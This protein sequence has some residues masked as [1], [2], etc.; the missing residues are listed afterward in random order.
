MRNATRSNWVIIASLGILFSGS[1]ICSGIIVVSGDATP[2]FYLADR[3]HET[4]PGNQTFF[5]NILDDGTNV[6]LSRYS[7]YPLSIHRIK[8]YYNSLPG[9]TSSTLGSAITNSDLENIDLLILSTPNRAFSQSEVEA[10][11]GFIETNGSLFVIGE[12]LL[13]N[14]CHTHINELLSALNIDIQVN[15]DYFDMGSNHSTPLS[16]PLTDGIDSFRY[17]ATSSVTGGTPLFLT[18]SGEAFI[19]VIP[20]PATAL[21]LG[22]GCMILRKR[23]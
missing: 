22:I 23:K 16:H 13:R 17:G 12:A 5:S 11:S 15:F 14:Q 21:L 3:Y 20:E 4:I 18:S 7:E 9:V 1:S 10:I 19:A 8:D 2:A 6:A